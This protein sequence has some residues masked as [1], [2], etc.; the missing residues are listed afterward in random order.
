[1]RDLHALQPATRADWVALAKTALLMDLA[2][3]FGWIVIVA[4]GG[5]T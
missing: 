5:H 4:L 3:V 2:I 1:M